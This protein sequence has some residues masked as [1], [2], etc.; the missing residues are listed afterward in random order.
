ML[1]SLV[2]ETDLDSTALVVQW[3][4]WMPK[5]CEVDQH[6]QS[7]LILPLRVETCCDLGLACEGCPRLHPAWL[8]REEP[9]F[10]SVLYTLAEGNLLQTA[11]DCCMFQAADP[12]CEAWSDPVLEVAVEAVARYTKPYKNDIH[13]ARRVFAP[14]PRETLDARHF[15]SSARRSTKRAGSL[16]S[17]LKPAPCRP[18]R[19]SAWGTIYLAR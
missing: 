14:G 10:F 4:G 3:L 9:E 12:E 18:A 6:G 16:G 19:G 7:C 5:V 8:A 1:K 11:L 17:S 2:R 13:G 15:H